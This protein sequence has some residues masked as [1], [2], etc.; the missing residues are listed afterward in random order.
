MQQN[1]VEPKERTKPLGRSRKKG[2]VIKTTFHEILD[3]DRV[4]REALQGKEEK[5][6]AI[7]LREGEP[8][9]Q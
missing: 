4:R 8:G 5:V 6:S 9:R 2:V 7:L 1:Q 3:N